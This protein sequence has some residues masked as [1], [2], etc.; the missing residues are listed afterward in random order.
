MNINFSFSDFMD[1]E[2]YCKLQSQFLLYDYSQWHE[3][4]EE[5]FTNKIITYKLFDVISGE[6]DYIEK[7]FVSDYLLPGIAKLSKMHFS[8]FIDRINTNNLF[9]SELQD[10]LAKVYSNRI[11]MTD[12]SIKNS[13]FLSIGIKALLIKQLNILQKK[14]ETFLKDPYPNLSNRLQ[15][16]WNRTDVIYF[17]YLLRANKQIKYITDGDLGR[18]I[19]SVCEFKNSENEHVEIGNSRKHLNAF[20][21]VEGRSASLSEKRIKSIFKNDDYYNI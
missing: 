12:K 2:S 15:F 16:N 14:I 11:N 17:F 8:R 1:V 10:G 7:Q 20:K 18:I 4:V 5:P 13:K 6:E 3:K 19:D 21:N 9:S